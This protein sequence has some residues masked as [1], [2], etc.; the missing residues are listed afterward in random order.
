MLTRFSSASLRKRPQL[1][2]SGKNSYLSC[3]NELEH[4][5]PLSLLQSWFPL[6]EDEELI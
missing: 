6:Q 2:F 3:G 1:H 5:P 4:P